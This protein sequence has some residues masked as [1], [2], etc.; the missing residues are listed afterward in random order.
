MVNSVCAKDALDK[1]DII[2]SQVRWRKRRFISF[3]SPLSYSPFLEKSFHTP[4]HHFAYFF[5][6]PLSSN[7]LQV[8]LSVVNSQ[9][10]LWQM[11]TSRNILWISSRWRESWKGRN[12]YP[13]FIF[14][15]Q[16]ANQTLPRPFI[17]K[18]LKNIIFQSKRRRNF[19]ICRC[20]PLKSSQKKKPFQ[21]FL[22][23]H[24]AS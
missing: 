18:I 12:S 17:N 3:S 1:E 13:P 11:N 10:H 23:I 24:T 15:L 14:L 19:S 22:Q 4:T 7:Y 16:K 8:I 9:N 21:P 20:N 6:N 5:N 2:I